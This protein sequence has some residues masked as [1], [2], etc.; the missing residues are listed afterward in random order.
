MTYAGM[1]VKDARKRTG[2]TQ[3]QLAEHS[4]VSLSTIRKLEQGERSGARMETMHALARALRLPTMSLVTEPDEEGA[5]AETRELWEPVRAELMRPPSREIDAPATPSGVSEVLATTVPLYRNHRFSELA[6]MLPTLLRDADTLP[7]EGRSVRVRVLQLA[8]SALTHTRQFDL[9]EIVVR[10]ALAE[11]QDRMSAAASVNT[12]A[13]LLLRQG[14]LDEALSL[15]TQWADDMEPRLSRASTAELATWGLLLLRA[16]G[17]AARNNQAGVAADMLR[18]ARSAATAIGHEVDAEHQNVRTF[19]PTS[20]RMLSV[21]DALIKDRPD[22][23]LRLAE[24]MP[25]YSVR[26]TRSVR[27]RHG[28]DVANAHARLGQFTE[29]FG[30]LTEVQA[31]SPEWF[32]NQTSAQHTLQTIIDGRRTLTPEMRHMA[33]TLRLER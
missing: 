29:A 32:L 15:A 14:R 2:L 27:S 12:L 31:G 28:L 20:V 11:G 24:N 26:P 19:G 4:G 8:A 18:L 16:S 23:A 30:K 25:R 1:K 21:E 22:V 10:R 3:R 5:R 33:D 7:D 9:A 6:S 13:W 17:A